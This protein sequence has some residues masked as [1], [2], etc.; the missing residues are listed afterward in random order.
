MLDFSLTCS[1]ASSAVWGLLDFSIAPPLLFYA[2]IPIIVISLFL[3][4]FVLIKEKFSLRS[5]LLFIVSIIFTSLLLNE[6]LLWIAA[7]VSLVEFGWQLEPLFRILVAVFTVYFIYAFI[8]K[9]DLPFTQK[10]ILGTAYISVILLTPTTSN[11]VFFDLNNCE[12]IPGRLFDLTHLF[13]V[14]SM[15]W[16]AVITV[17]NSLQASMPKSEK[18][19]NAFLGGAAVLFLLV[20]FASTFFGDV[21]K[22]YEIGLLGPVGMV[23]FMAFLTFIIVRYRAFNIKLIGAQALIVSL[24]VVIGSEFFFIQNT[25]NQILT[26]ITLVITG[27]IGINLIRSVKKE[28]AQ[29][30]HIEKLAGELQA[31]NERQETLMHFVGHEV[32]GFLTKDAGAFAAISQGDFGQCDVNMKPFVERALVESRQGAA[33]VENILKASNLKKGTVAYT[34]A[35]FDMKE[36]V[37][38]AVEKAKPAAGLKGLTLTFTADEGSYQMNGDK[39][40]INDHVLRNLIDNSINYT[41]SGSVAVSLKRA[42]TK[43]IFEVKDTGIGITDEDKKRLFTEGGHGKDSQTVN[44]HSTGYG[45]YIAKQITEAHNGTIRA[46]SEGEGKGTTF[47]VELPVKPVS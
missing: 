20:F 2:Y 44:A 28:V 11:I 15:L 46:E 9:R 27:F 38:E 6:I 14:V 23:T 32:K 8:N 22:V 37:A 1:D 30:E 42:S 35:P 19:Q 12:G 3:G 21:T 41:P 29:R 16:V 45:L 47:F 33:S 7:P 31:T 17:K 4:G 25:T 43:I 40:Q 39:A 13:E 24:V 10:L 18:Y 26:A 34:K 5:K 36:L